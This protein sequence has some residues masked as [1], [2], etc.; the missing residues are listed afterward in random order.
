MQDFSNTLDGVNFNTVSDSAQDYDYITQAL[1]TDTGKMAS[2]TNIGYNAMVG[3][4]NAQLRN[5]EVF[6][7]YGQQLDTTNRNMGTLKDATTTATTTMQNDFTRTSGVFN[8]TLIQTFG[9]ESLSNALA[10]VPQVFKKVFTQSANIVLGIF[11]TMID[12]INHAMTVTWSDFEIGGEKVLT[13]GSAQLF[14]INRI[15]MFAMGGFPEDGLFFA[16]SSEMVGRFT[17]GKTAVANNEQIV[18]GIEQGVYNAMISAMNSGANNVN[19]TL[20][21]DAE[22]IFRVVQ[23]Q[24]RIYKKSTGASAFD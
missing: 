1:T 21:G 15:P 12:A 11:N 6:K 18:A 22:G 10:S 2:A 8:K 19:V 17:N 14:S 7:Q 9:A 24:N 3:L 16:N 5:V 4:S 23:K 13:G 20:E